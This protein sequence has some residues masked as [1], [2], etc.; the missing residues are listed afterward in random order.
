M[1][2]IIRVNDNF[3]KIY[4]R[5]YAQTNCAYKLSFIISKGVTQMKNQKQTGIFLFILT[6]IAAAVVIIT[7][8]SDCFVFVADGDGFAD[9]SPADYQTIELSHDDVYR[10][11]LILIRSDIPCK[12]FETEEMTRLYDLKER[13]YQLGNADIRL[14]REAAEA[15]DVML[16]DFCK[17]VGSNDINVISGFRSVELQQKLFEEKTELCGEKEAQRWVARPGYSEHHSGYAVDFGIYRNGA[18][19]KFNGKGKYRWLQ[20]HA[21]EYGF[22]LRYATEKEKTT[23][24]AG[25]SWHFRYVGV[26]HACYMKQKQMC[27]EEYE[28]H[29]KDYSYRSKHMRVTDGRGKQYEVYYVKAEQNITEVPVPRDADYTV[30]GNNVDG[31]IVTAC[32]S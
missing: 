16:K 25:E 6:L 9:F 1:R 14:K 21:H 5:A 32:L 18:S 11:D 13:S 22:V 19:S 15:L 28:R 7:Y 2:D 29:I 23:G 26:P 31:F 17:A 24:I 27:L 3:S 20:A 10:G 12:N 4:L 8:A 30:S